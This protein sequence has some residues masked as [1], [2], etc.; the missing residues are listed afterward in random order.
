M[1]KISQGGGTTALGNILTGYLTPRTS[2]TDKTFPSLFS[3][4]HPVL[5]TKHTH[6]HSLSFF[7]FF[8]FFFYLLSRSLSLFFLLLLLVL[9]LP[10]YISH[11]VFLPIFLYY[12]LFIS[13]SLYIFIYI[14]HSL[15]HSL[16]PSFAFLTPQRDKG[17]TYCSC[18]YIRLGIKR[19]IFSIP[20]NTLPC[21]SLNT[22]SA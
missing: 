4:G 5:A 8:F 18:I 10:T 21:T 15:I 1:G 22:L 17:V 13:L 3:I 12:L 16:S 11:Y 14:S 2:E 19:H 20:S 9:L 6:T 7:L